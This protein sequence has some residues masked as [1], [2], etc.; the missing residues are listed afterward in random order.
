MKKGV[1]YLVLSISVIF[2]ACKKDEGLNDSDHKSKFIKTMG[3]NAEGVDI[4]QTADGGY[5][6]LGTIQGESS[7]DIYLKRVDAR[8]NHI[9][10][11]SYDGPLGDQNE[12][13]SRI[14]VLDDGG[15]AIVGTTTIFDSNSTAGFINATLLL[16]TDF[17]GNA[18]TRPALAFATGSNEIGFGIFISP[19]GDF[20]LAS[21]VTVI[22]SATGQFKN[23]YIRLI[24]KNDYSVKATVE[25]TLNSSGPGSNLSFRDILVS[26]NDKVVLTGMTDQNGVEEST[27]GESLL[28]GVLQSDTSTSL[29]KN[30]AYGELD[31]DIGHRIIE[32]S[33][34]E[35]VMCGYSVISGNKQLYAIN[36]TNAGVLEP[37]PIPQ[38]TYSGDHSG[39]NEAFDI[40]EVSDGYVI[41]GYTESNDDRQFYIVKINSTGSSVVWEKEYGYVD[42]DEAKAIVATDDNGLAVLG[43]SSDER[44]NRVMTLLKLDANGNLK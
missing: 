19:S 35:V 31:S 17:E 2:S 13:A 14:Q 25:G 18:R 41:A 27:R 7:K 32:N 5:I 1:L 33:K 15:Y 3:T 37:S 23:G 29:D 4:K 38:W 21:E 11:R 16:V 39:E 28:L 34:D 8:G 6:L 44:G 40:V 36:F 9:W 26:S 24:D 42:F 12:T 30:L 43:T 10:S 22:L 20:V